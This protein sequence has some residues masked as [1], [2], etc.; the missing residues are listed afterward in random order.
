[1]L[2]QLGRAGGWPPACEPLCTSG[3]SPLAGVLT[4]WRSSH[5]SQG[6]TECTMT[7]SSILC[8]VNYPVI[9]ITY[10]KVLLTG[11]LALQGDCIHPFP[12]QH[13]CPSPSQCLLL[14]C[15]S[16]RAAPLPRC[17]MGAMREQGEG[18]GVGRGGGNSWPQ[19]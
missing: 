4:L 17:L 12:G 18:W 16:P 3:P 19:P 11:E 6:L 14:M 5:C 10:R 2:P 13:T 1:M 15:L 8:G 9:F 7:V